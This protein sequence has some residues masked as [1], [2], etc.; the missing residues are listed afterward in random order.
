MTPAIDYRQLSG[1]IA[2]FADPAEAQAHARTLGR[3]Y[4][5]T[6]GVGEVYAVRRLLPETYDRS[7]VPVDRSYRPALRKFVGPDDPKPAEVVIDDDVLVIQLMHAL[8]HGGLVLHRNALDGKV[9]MSSQ[10]TIKVDCIYKDTY[11]AIDEN[12]YDGAPDSGTNQMGHGKT[13]SQAVEDLL[14]QLEAIA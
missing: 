6:P 11:T 7:P 12:T 9:H 8:R 14:E 13:P 10:L 5:V 1:I 2:E 3:D 4:V